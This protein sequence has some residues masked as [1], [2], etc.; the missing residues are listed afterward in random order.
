MAADL[1]THQTPVTLQGQTVMVHKDASGVT[2]GGAKVTSADLACK[3]GVIHTI[4]KVVLPPAVTTT[5]AAM[6]SP[7]AAKGVAASVAVGVA[8]MVLA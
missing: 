1:K 2:F 4:D 7:A 3:N 5:A 8:M 6:T